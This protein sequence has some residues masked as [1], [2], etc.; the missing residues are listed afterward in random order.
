MT[1]VRPNRVNKTLEEKQTL[2]AS[3][4]TLATISEGLKTAVDVD[5]SKCIMVPEEVES[6]E[7]FIKWI[8]ELD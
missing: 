5:G 4:E 6:E 8:D 7:D 3:F 1:K 2:I